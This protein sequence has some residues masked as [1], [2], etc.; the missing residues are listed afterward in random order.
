[1]LSPRISTGLQQLLVH[2]SLERARA[3]V[4]TDGRVAEAVL[5]AL[6]H[7]LQPSWPNCDMQIQAAAALGLMCALSVVEPRLAPQQMAAGRP[8]RSPPPV[9]P[10]TAAPGPWP[11]LL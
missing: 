4:A 6:C 2:I 5:A 9:P 7:P 11:V 8:V 1:M 10:A 3:D